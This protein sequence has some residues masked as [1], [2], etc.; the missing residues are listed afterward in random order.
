MNFFQDFFLLQGTTLFSCPLRLPSLTL[1]FCDLHK[2]LFILFDA[3][4]SVEFQILLGG[5]KKNKNS[6]MHIGIEPMAFS[7]HWSDHGV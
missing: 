5:L 7:E 2:K 1:L 6:D 3:A 4:G